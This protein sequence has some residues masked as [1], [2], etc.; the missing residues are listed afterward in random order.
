MEILV[1]KNYPFVALRKRAYLIS[2]TLIMISLLMYVF[3]G[4]NYGVDFVGG[5]SIEL[6]FKD[7]VEV[8]QIRS[9]VSSKY[10]ADRI[11]RL[12]EPNEVLVH[13]IE[14]QDRVANDLADLLRKSLPGNTVELRSVSKVGPKM[15]DELK[16]AAVWAT[17]WGLLFIVAYLA[18]RFHWKWGLAAVIALAH[19]VLITVGFFVALQLEFSLAAVAALLTIVGY[20]VNDTIVV[21]DRIRENLRFMKRGSTFDDIVNQSINQTLSRTIMTSALTLLSVLVLLILGGE[22]LRVFAWALLVGIVVG[23]YSSIFVASPVLIEW[24]AGE[25]LKVKS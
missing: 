4:L 14:Q 9:L 10:G 20:S 3:V 24:K 7:P 18:I 21:F 25:D 22:V 12:G 15:G 6:K 1:N 19:D 13:V 16:S 8:D 2:G 11:Q 17:I 23:T 5:T